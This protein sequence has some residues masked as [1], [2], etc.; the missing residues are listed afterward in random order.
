MYEYFMILIVIMY[1]LFY[2]WIYS[3][4]SGL[5]ERQGKIK[6]EIDKLSIISQ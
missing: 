5:K 2:I 3:E 4:I 6:E 1:I